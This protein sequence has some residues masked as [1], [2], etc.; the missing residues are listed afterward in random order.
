MLARMKEMLVMGVATGIVALLT[1]TIGFFTIMVISIPTI[2]ELA[3]IASLGV[4]VITLTNFFLLPLM[5]SYLR[6]PP[7][8]ADW[9]TTRRQRGALSHR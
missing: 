7:S 3:L 8:Y 9:V 4:S 6:L 1:D 2:Q 5:L